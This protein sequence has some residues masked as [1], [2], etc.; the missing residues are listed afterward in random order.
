MF[1]KYRTEVLLIDPPP[2]DTTIEE[3]AAIAKT[4]ILAC[5]DP[6]AIEYDKTFCAGI[7]GQIHIAKVTRSDGFQW[8]VAPQIILAAK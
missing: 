2:F 1:S 8:I 7:G 4:H 5:C 6:A 3:A